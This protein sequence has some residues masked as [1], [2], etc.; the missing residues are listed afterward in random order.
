MNFKLWLKGI[1]RRPPVV[2]ASLLVLAALGFWMVNRLV[3]RFG[4]QKKA[5]GRHLFQQSQTDLRRGQAD[6]AID[7]LRAALDYSPNDFDY[8]LAL[9][10]V[11]RDTG[12]NNSARNGEAESYLISLWERDPQNS[13][14]NLAIAR[15][16]AS[17]NLIE[18]ALQYY[19]NAI[20]GVWPTEAQAKRRDTQLELVHFLLAA[21]AYPQAQAELIS[22]SSGLP[23]GDIDLRLTVADLFVQAR[24]YDHALAQYQ[25]VLRHDHNNVQALSGAGSAAY[26]LGRYRTAQ[27]YLASAVQKNEST[28][29]T[30]QF[31]ETTNRVIEMNP[32]AQHISG[33]E[34]ARRVLHDF[35]YAR[36][37]LLA[38]AKEKG[39][40]ITAPP[41]ADTRPGQKATFSDTSPSPDALTSLYQRWLALKPKVAAL[42]MDSGN[43]VRDSA[44]DITFEIEQQTA[45]VCGTPTG[46]D[47]ALLLLSQNPTGASR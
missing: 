28:P 37:R 45:N 12:K 35:D 20:Y 8:Q 31:L 44:L 23:Y 30:R 9:A 14:V 19:H 17:E 27:H 22:W 21:K 5:L 4:E 18:K 29:D 3:N 1:A 34:S 36:A 33:K 2:L 25:E 42:R 47:L 16:Y 24:D 15:L 39:V 40:T 26:Q 46:A 13:L 6:A 32:Y 11:L 41:P 43:T 38:C 10:R 7:D